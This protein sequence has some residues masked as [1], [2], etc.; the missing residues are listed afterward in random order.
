MFARWHTVAE[1]WPTA[2]R[3]IYSDAFGASERFVISP[4]HERDALFQMPGGQSGH[5]LSPNYADGQDDWVNG[6]SIPFLP[7]PTQHTLVLNP[8]NE[9]LAKPPASNR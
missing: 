3:Q 7:G 9:A 4:G 8:A 2:A 5:P 1:R 6:R